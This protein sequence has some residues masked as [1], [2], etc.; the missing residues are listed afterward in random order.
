MD[1]GRI[2][3]AAP[4]PHRRP[5]PCDSRTADPGVLRLRGEVDRE[6]VGRVCARLT[7][8]RDLASAAELIAASGVREIDVADVTFADSALV[9]L[10]CAVQRGT[11]P[12]P[13]RV[14]GASPF[15]RRLFALTGTDPL[16]DLRG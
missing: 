7:G 14:R 11:A 16:V 1:D 3:Q 10:A 12:H 2:T 8:R 4:A 5:R 9:H 13:V 6:A 15:V